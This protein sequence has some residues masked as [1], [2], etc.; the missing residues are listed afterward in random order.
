MECGLAVSPGIAIGK[1]FVYTNEISF[2]DTYIETGQIDLELEQLKQGVASAKAEIL[3]Q[4]L[5]VEGVD[6]T[7]SEI[8]KA[9]SRLID[10]PVLKKM[11]VDKIKNSH[12]NAPTALNYTILH[13]EEVLSK[14]NTEYMRQRASDIKDIGH[15]IL[16]KLLGIEDEPCKMPGKFVIVAKDLMPSDILRLDK[17]N[18]LGFIT[19][20]G[21]VTS[22]TA[23]IARSAGIPAVTGIPNISA[24]LHPGDEVIVD[25]SS[26]KVLI[27]PDAVTFNEYTEKQKIFRQQIEVSKEMKDVPAV[28]K[29]GKKIILG[30]N[31]GGVD[32]ITPALANGAEKIGLFRT[33]FIFMAKNY[34]PGEDEQ[35]GIYKAVIDGMKGRPVIIRTLDV[36]GDKNIPYLQIQK[37]D[38]PFLG[39]RGIRYCLI[40]K[41]IFS[42]QLKAILRASGTSEVTILLPMVSCVKEVVK[43]RELIDELKQELR[44]KGLPVGEN[45]KVGIMVEVPSAALT[46]EELAEVADYFSIGTNDLSQYVLAIDRTNKSLEN[47][48][49]PGHP[50]LLRLIRKIVED[51]HTKGKK[52]GVCGEMA[53]NTRYTDFFIEVGIDELSMNAMSIHEVKQKINSR[54]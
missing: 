31:I 12:M 13:L 43:T 35:Y 39:L 49:D 47:L 8:L 32:D 2:S 34:L 26:G 29:N 23:I 38:N 46:I 24:R 27:N 15:R 19:E 1:A 52:V 45:I 7:Q 6:Q 50:A 25:G 22:H 44:A 40:N 9:H 3:S 41:D 21:G 48:Y 51:A 10:D 16:K 54:E 28:A 18:I 53:G 33:E 30:A 37:E 36:G 20:V 42:S 5:D 11:A 14:M 4:L 17:T